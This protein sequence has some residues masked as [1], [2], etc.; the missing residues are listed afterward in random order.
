MTARELAEMG[1]DSIGGDRGGNV[2]YLHGPVD[3]NG[4]VPVSLR[5]PGGPSW[6]GQGDSR[7]STHGHPRTGKATVCAGFFTRKVSE[8]HVWKFNIDIQYDF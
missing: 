3:T 8:I 5:G 1:V 4:G 2:A 6:G 7:A